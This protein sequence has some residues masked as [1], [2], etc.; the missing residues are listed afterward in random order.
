MSPLPVIAAALAAILVAS[1]AGPAAPPEPVWKEPLRQNIRTLGYRNW[2]VVADASFPAHSR[3]GVRVTFLDAETPEVVDAV[4]QILEETETLQ[5]RVFVPREMRQIENQ[6]APGIEEFRPRLETALHGRIATELD[7]ASLMTLLE[8]ATRTLDVLVL[9]TNTAL[10]YTSVF[11]ELQHGYWDGEAE[12]ILRGKLKPS[13]P[14]EP[15]RGPLTPVPAEG[16][17]PAA[18]AP[19]PA[20]PTSPVDPL[21]VPAT[22]DVPAR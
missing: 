2:I 18:P 6:Y 5:P 17:V 20:A 13:P 9:K 4:L 19:A 16:S 10:P 1:C 11:L 3:R 15:Y 22:M 14:P 7:Q 21:A 8:D 12:M